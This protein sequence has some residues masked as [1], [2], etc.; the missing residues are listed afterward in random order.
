[1]RKGISPIVASVILIAAT[2][3]IAG[4]LSFWA[5]GF[6]RTR[7][8]ESENVTGE[9]VCLGA[10]FKFYSGRYDKDTK[11][12]YLILDNRRNVDLELENLYLF[13]PNNLMKTI[14]LKDTLK[15]NDIRSYNVTGVDDGFE[16]MKIKTNCPE[17]S[18][19]IAYSSVVPR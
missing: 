13:Y 5:T 6:I 9:T 3:S 11:T 1:M 18:L 19:D 14:P 8:T 17:V 12:L 15:A 4:I 7:L 16:N 10:D 2:M